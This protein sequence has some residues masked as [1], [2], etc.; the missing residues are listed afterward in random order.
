[1]IEKAMKQVH[2]SLKPNRA[3][4]L[5]ALETIAKLKDVIPIEKAQMK[6]RVL[7]HKKHRKQLRE[8][9]AEVELENISGDGVLEMI[10]L[11]DPGHYRAIDLLIKDSPKAQLHVLSLREVV[12]GD[13]SLGLECNASTSK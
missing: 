13:E 6:L 8:M 12:D 9:A 1:M 10:F 7:C 3:A 4:K 5:Q 2:F 11:A